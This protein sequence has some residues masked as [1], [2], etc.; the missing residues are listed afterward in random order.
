M[1][2]LVFSF[3]PQLFKIFCL[4]FVFSVKA[5]NQI[6]EKNSNNFLAI[7]K[8]IIIIIII[9]LYSSTDPGITL[10]LLPNPLHPLSS[11]ILIQ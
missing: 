10:T 6:Y 2:C 1:V 4:S 11:P 3:L 8:C 9:L 7:F 5:C